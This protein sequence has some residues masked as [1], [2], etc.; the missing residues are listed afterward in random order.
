MKATNSLYEN[1]KVFLSE[2]FGFLALLPLGLLIN[3]FLPNVQIHH[4][5]VTMIFSFLVALVVIRIMIDL[6]RPLVIPATLLLFSVL[7]YNQLS[8]GYTLVNAVHDYSH[9]VTGNWNAR[10]QKEISSLNVV[11][12]LWGDSRTQL[13]D[14]LRSRA[15]ITDPMVRNFAVK[16]SLESFDNAFPKYQMVARELSLFKYINHNFKYVPD[17]KDNEYYAT[18]KETILNGLGGDC[19]DHAILMGSC[20]EAIGAQ[21]RLVVI[22]G[23]MYPELYVGNKADFDTFQQAVRTLFADEHVDRIFYHAHNGEYWVNLD[24]SAPYPGGPYLN[25]EVYLVANL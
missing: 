5:V 15:T 10:D 12:D 24:Y 11:P 8:G 14:T 1:T 20:M 9:Y 17:P 13:A 21:A 6:F 16:H 22:K 18:P 4:F 7:V 23:H 19:D 3:R 2:I 25:N